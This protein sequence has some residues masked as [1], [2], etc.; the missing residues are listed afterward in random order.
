MTHLRRVLGR[1]DDGFQP[2]RPVAVVLDNDLGL[3]VRG[4][5]GQPAVLAH[6]RQSAGRPVGQR[7]S[8]SINAGVLSQA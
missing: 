8:S 7:D 3:T 4:E 6:L 1:N 2:H 5:A